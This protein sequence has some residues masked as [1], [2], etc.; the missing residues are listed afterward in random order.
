MLDAPEFGRPA[1][2]LF[3]TLPGFRDR[4]RAA[5]RFLATAESDPDYGWTAEVVGLV[6]SENLLR[7][8][9]LLRPLLGRI[10]LDDAILRVLAREPE[11]ADRAAFV[12]GLDAGEPATV[13]A[14]L[15]AIDQLGPSGAPAEVAALIGALRR[16]P[17]GLAG[18]ILSERAVAALRRATGEALTADPAAWSDWFVGAYPDRAAEL[19]GT[20]G[21]DFEAWTRRLAAID[22]S[23]GDPA[24][25]L[26]AFA[27]ARCAACHSGNRA[28]GPDLRGI[29]GRFSRD[30][31]FTAI[32]RPDRDVSPQFRS[33]LVATVDGSI[34]QGVVIYE[35]AD[36]VILQTGATETVRIDAG[37]I[38]ERRESSGSLMPAGLLDE[39]S[40]AEIADLFV[41]LKTLR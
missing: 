18:E 19:L 6:G 5:D 22:W 11:E 40:D 16:A 13:A 23:E 30:D 21:A 37:A 33:V 32:L 17:E 10:G 20:G 41:Y 36:G 9:P 25:G 14:C 7:A 27:K 4:E 38:E 34:Y 15:E 2:A 31:L 8:K 24:R 26:A 29:G 35:A 3:A 28:V 39:L 12:D 1:H